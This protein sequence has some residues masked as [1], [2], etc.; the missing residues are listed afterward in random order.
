MNTRTWSFC[1]F[2]A[3]FMGIPGTSVSYVRSWYNT[4]GHDYNVPRS[5]SA[6]EAG[7]FVE[8]IISIVSGQYA[9]AC[10]IPG[11]GCGYGC[12]CG[13]NIHI[14]TRHFC[15]VRTISA[16]T[17]C[18]CESIKLRRFSPRTFCVPY[19][20]L[21]TPYRTQNLFAFCKTSKR[22]TRDTKPQITYPRNTRR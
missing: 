20:R 22:P 1:E 18:F 5:C 16:Y 3:A 21:S 12:G 6:F 4:R 9:R 11:Y 10:K 19:V 15:E 8:N 17:R 14:A 7:I 2:S 13:Y